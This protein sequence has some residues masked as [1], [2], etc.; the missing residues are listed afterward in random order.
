MTLVT[1]QRDLVVGAYNV[2]VTTGRMNAE[3][4]GLGSEIYDAD[5]HYHEVRRNWWGISIT[6]AN[7][8]R[9]KHDLWETHGR[10]SPV[11]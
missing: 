3:G 2:L 11:K 1:D 7:G 5:A 9:E 6:H 8:H 4:L 10:H